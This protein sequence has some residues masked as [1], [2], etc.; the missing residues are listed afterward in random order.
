MP[1]VSAFPLHPEK[2]AAAKTNVGTPLAEPAFEK[3]SKRRIFVVET[4]WS[5][6]YA[7]KNSEMG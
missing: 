1:P 7:R 3:W 4:A 2:G 6:P 5:Y